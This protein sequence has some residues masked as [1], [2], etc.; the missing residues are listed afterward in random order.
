LVIAILISFSFKN[1]FENLK[2]FPLTKQISCEVTK[3]H[4]TSVLTFLQD[5]IFRINDKQV[6]ACSRTIWIYFPRSPKGSKNNEIKIS[7]LN[8]LCSAKLHCFSQKKKVFF[9]P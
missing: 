1:K 8:I 7:E 4:L 6:I 3:M 9:S 5:Y 2:H